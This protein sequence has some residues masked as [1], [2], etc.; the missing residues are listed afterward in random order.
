MSEPTCY[1][2]ARPIMGVPPRTG[3]FPTVRLAS[4]I[5]VC[6]SCSAAQGFTC[7]RPKCTLQP[8]HPGSCSE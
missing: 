1:L 3:I 5:L 8:D 7:P 4:G 6:K 2:C